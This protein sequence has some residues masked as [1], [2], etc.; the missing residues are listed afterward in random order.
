MPGSFQ[1]WLSA[2]VPHQRRL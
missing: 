1:K 2:T